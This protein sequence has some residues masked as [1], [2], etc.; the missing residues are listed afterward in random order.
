MVVENLWQIITGIITTIATC[1]M[2]YYVYRLTNKSRRIEVYF[3]HLCN[4]LQNNVMMDMS[5]IFFS[6]PK[7]YCIACEAP[8][9]CALIR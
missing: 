6:S 7:K 1:L 9:F 3:E 2:T 4:W 8:C 5:R